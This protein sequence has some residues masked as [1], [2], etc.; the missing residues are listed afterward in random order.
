MSKR[1]PTFRPNY[2]VDGP[3]GDGINEVST[4]VCRW[5]W[6]GALVILLAF[7]LGFFGTRLGWL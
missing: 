5:S 1:P 6:R 3:H 2:E 7:L 4:F